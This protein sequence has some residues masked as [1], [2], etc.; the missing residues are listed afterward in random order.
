MAMIE[1]ARIIKKLIEDEEFRYFFNDMQE[2][3]N[4]LISDPTCNC[5]KNIIQII[6]NRLTGK[7]NKLLN[8]WQVINCKVDDLE[9]KL[10]KK[11]KYGMK[12]YAIARF[13]DDVVC[14]INQQESEQ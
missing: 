9:C 12:N 2:D 1:D 8:S 6:K 14:V 13:N 5:N 7:N 10:N 3:I 11:H 4:I